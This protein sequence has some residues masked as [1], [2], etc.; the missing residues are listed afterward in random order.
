MRHP[1]QMRLQLQGAVTPVQITKGSRSETGKPMVP[2]GIYCY[3]SEVAMVY[4]L[5]SLPAIAADGLQRRIA[6]FGYYHP[7]KTMCL[8]MI[9]PKSVQATQKSLHRCPTQLGLDGRG[10]HQVYLT[11]FLAKHQWRD[12]VCRWDPDGKRISVWLCAMG[13]PRLVDVSGAGG[14]LFRV[15]IDSQMLKQFSERPGG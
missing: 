2:D 15:R 1:T 13:S 10:A 3:R 5:S 8:R 4:A 12:D 7:P 6:S 9:A 14:T 11:E